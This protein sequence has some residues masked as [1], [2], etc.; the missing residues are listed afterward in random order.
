ML[1]PGLNY[2]GNMPIEPAVVKYGDRPLYLIAGQDKDKE[3]FDAVKKLN[4]IVNGRAVHE[5]TINPDGDHGTG[6]LNVGASEELEDF[7][8]RKLLK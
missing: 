1:S 6:L 5:T 4:P 8:V 7:F 3:S 2:F